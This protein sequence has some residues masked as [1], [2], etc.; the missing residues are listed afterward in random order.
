MYKAIAG[1]LATRLCLGEPVVLR[2]RVLSSHFRLLF[3]LARSKDLLHGL[4]I[5]D[6][7]V[8]RFGDLLED[9]IAVIVGSVLPDGIHKRGIDLL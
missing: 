4:D 9:N 6:N 2:R 1:T 8:E 3:F 7:D 5:V